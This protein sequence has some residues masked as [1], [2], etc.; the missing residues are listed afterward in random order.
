MHWIYEQMQLLTC[1]LQEK[2]F[3]LPP[4]HRGLPFVLK[5]IN[6]VQFQ[7]SFEWSICSTLKLPLT[8]QMNTVVSDKKHHRHMFANTTMAHSIRSSRLVILHHPESHM[9][10]VQINYFHTHVSV[11]I[12][13][14]SIKNE[15]N[16][17]LIFS[18]N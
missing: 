9:L 10:T 3:L 5:R 12:L 13:L 8:Q 6:V 16:R 7:F 2:Y 14:Q 15:D 4:T 17:F 18:A 11:G 1:V